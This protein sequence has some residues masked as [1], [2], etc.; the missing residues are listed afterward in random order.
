MVQF[1]EIPSNQR[2]PLFATEIDNSRAIQ[3]VTTKEYNVLCL[4]QRLSSGTKPALIKE[5][6]TSDAQARLFY[7]AGSMIAEMLATFRAS[8]LSIKLTALPLEDDGGGVAA[9]GDQIFVGTAT[10]AGTIFFYL[11]GLRMTLGVA[12]GDTKENIATNLVAVINGKL[13]RV[14]NA[15]V[16]GGAADK[17]NFTARNKGAESS[18]L[19][20]RFNIEDGEEFP[21]GITLGA[22]NQLS[23]G[24]SNPDV[25][26]AIA[27]FG[28]T[29]WDFIINPYNDGANLTL[30]ESELDDRFSATKQIGGNLIGAKRGNFS[31]LSSLGAGRNSKHTT[32]IAQEG[33]TP[34]FLWAADA[35]AVI[36][37]ST[38]IDQ[39]RPYQTLALSNV[40]APSES[41]LLNNQERNL[42][43]FDGISATKV[44]AGNVV[45]IER[46]ITGFQVNDF[47]AEDESFLDLNTLATLHF[48][49]FDWNNHL[50]LEFPRHKLANDGTK[51]AA[52]SPIVTPKTIRAEAIAKARE[53]EFLGLVENV[54]AFKDA[55][56][57][58]RPSS[59]VV[60][61]DTLLQ[62][63]LVNQFR[64]ARTLLQFLL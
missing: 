37:A 42:L 24:T 35:A 15:V 38:S 27:V 59:S 32:I 41:E 6:I 19:D 9:S 40:R 1:T 61:I 30:L 10:K 52:G 47:G 57:V 50:A 31:T 51:A 23:S 7:G 3:G 13:N 26:A 17:I 62:P 39:A 33:P 46:I 11:A 5:V 29:Q 8:N 25:T 53:W 28:D 45:R 49:R 34:A 21:D 18:D 55:L 16:D 12:V 56:V 2:L 36:S 14:I 4:G 60:T 64:I 58:E 48:L 43:L 20:F 54:D 44:G 63:D 22:A